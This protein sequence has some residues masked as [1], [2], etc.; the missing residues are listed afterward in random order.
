MLEDSGINER[1]KVRNKERFCDKKRWKICVKSV[2]E[3]DVEDDG[4]LVSLK[5][6]LYLK[7]KF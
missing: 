5:I 3:F 4:K 1:N 2:E 6:S 7:T